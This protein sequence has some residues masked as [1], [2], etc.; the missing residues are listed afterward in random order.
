MAGRVSS[1]TTDHDTIR[2]WV[3]ERGG[4]PA[5]VG[6]TERGDETGIIRIDFPGYGGEGKL[7]RIPWDDWFRKFDEANLAFTYEETTAG[8]QRSNFN[9]L[10][11]RE[12]ADARARGRRTSRRA[13][14]AGRGGA[15]S[16]ARAR[17]RT[18]AGRAGA[19]SARGGSRTRKT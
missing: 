15:R 13:S 1:T 7:E 6:G 10:I 2:R 18:S 14:R 4:W 8:G 5:S 9:K 19:R 3:E 16:G 17:S 11:G 12:T